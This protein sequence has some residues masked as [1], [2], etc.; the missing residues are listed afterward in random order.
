VLSDHNLEVEGTLMKHCVGSYADRVREGRV[1]IFS[2]RDP[3][4]KPHVTVEVSDKL[5]KQIQGVANST[6]KDKYVA[7][8]REWF[9]TT[10]YKREVGYSSFRTMLND[11]D[12]FNGFI[13][14]KTYDFNYWLRALK[15][16]VASLLNTGRDKYGLIVDLYIPG[17]E[18]ID[19]FYKVSEV[20]GDYYRVKYTDALGKKVFEIIKPLMLYIL[21]DK[22]SHH[23]SF[24]I[25]NMKAK[26]ETML[27]GSEVYTED[28]ISFYA[29][30]QKKLV[31]FADQVKDR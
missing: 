22:P 27:R 2:L 12:A 25:N 11:D 16:K 31:E 4:N 15:E 20:A 10:D 8:L 18:I 28:W 5:V 29:F 9:L 30:F 14:Q 1:Q 21:K 26:Y 19:V 3:Q 24:V 23:I 17:N 13:D 6:P 7:Y